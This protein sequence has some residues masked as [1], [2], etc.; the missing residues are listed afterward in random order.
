MFLPPP[1]EAEF[2]LVGKEKNL[3]D[4]SIDSVLEEQVRDFYFRM[5][6]SATYHREAILMSGTARVEQLAK[7]PILASPSRNPGLVPAMFRI[8]TTSSKK[9]ASRLF[10]RIF[11]R[12]EPAE[13]RS[14]SG[15][16]KIQVEHFPLV[17][18]EER[19]NKLINRPLLLLPDYEREMEE[20][21]E[22]N[23]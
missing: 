6:Q 7:E 4:P 9:T 22:P 12:T 19:K 16:T 11:H 20:R 2:L 13:T 1:K 8:V 10:A 18:Y 15:P 14:V 17:L 21:D 3:V 23:N 5:Q